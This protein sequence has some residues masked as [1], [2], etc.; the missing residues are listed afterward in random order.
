MPRIIYC[1]V[2]GE[3]N[4]LQL[5]CDRIDCPVKAVS[6]PLID[7]A[8]RLFGLVQPTGRCKHGTTAARDTDDTASLELEAA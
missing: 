2:C 5:L 8:R 6:T 1:D 7:S 4:S 3:P